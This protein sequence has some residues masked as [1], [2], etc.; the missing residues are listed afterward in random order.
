[1]VEKQAERIKDLMQ[2]MR[3]SFE[4]GLSQ[5]ALRASKIQLMNA[6]PGHW[7]SAAA[8]ECMQ[9]YVGGN[10]YGAISVAQSYV[11]A[12][13]KFLAEN[14]K[15]RQSSDVTVMW[16]RLENK[17]IVTL[18]SRAAAEEIFSDR[19]DFHHL[20]KNLETDYLKLE[21]RGLVCINNLHI[22]ESDVFAYVISEGKIYPSWPKYWP[23]SNDAPGH[24]SVFL[25][26]L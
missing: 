20:N 17:S 8:S 19:N 21:S 5:A 7:F 23:E 10:F 25:R 26:N 4:A 9:M 24:I 15:I 1:M 2:S 22:I 13:G 3:A 6:I 11:E 18:D 14:Q 16:K 12:L